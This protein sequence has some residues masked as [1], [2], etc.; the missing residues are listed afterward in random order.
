MNRTFNHSSSFI[1]EYESIIK[2]TPCTKKERYSGHESDKRWFNYMIISFDKKS[3]ME[4]NLAYQRNETIWFYLT[5]F[6][7]KNNKIILSKQ[8]I[9]FGW[10]DFKSI[11][12][13]IIYNNLLQYYSVIFN[14][15]NRDLVPLVILK[16]FILEICL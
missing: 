9:S 4:N 12:D 14:F 8:Y 11:D 13:P 10:D 5:I 1:P 6:N 7:G 2:I 16:N 15:E 3:E